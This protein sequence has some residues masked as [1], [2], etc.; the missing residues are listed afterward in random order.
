[1]SLK[2]YK[3][4][5]LDISSICT[6]WSSI[7]NKSNRIIY[8]KIQSNKKNITLPEKLTNFRIE[9]IKLLKEIRPTHVVI[10]DVFLSR[11]PKVVM[12]LAK[13]GGIAQ[14]V[15]Y[16][17]TGIVPYVVSNTTPKSFFKAKKKDMLFNII[18]NLLDYDKKSLKFKEWNDVTDSIAQ[19]LY[20]CDKIIQVKKIREDKEYGFRYIY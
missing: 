2:N 14:Q 10:E 5:S 8:G 13:F 9:I 18:I 20:Y 19:L 4:L 17:V 12:I 7:S 3:I 1:M 6:G 11:N 15:I 16:E